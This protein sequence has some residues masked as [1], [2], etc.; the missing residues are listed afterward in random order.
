MT[1]TPENITSFTAVDQ[2][3]DPDFFVR[4]VDRANAL[5]SMQASK[6]ITLDAL[7]LQEG[8][9]VLDAGCGTGADVV[10]IARRV[11]PH[12][13]VVGVDVSETMVA[14]AR[15]RT[16]GTGLP[17]EFEVGDAQALRFADATFDAC[18]TERM[19]MHVPDAELALA[20][21]VRVT[22]PGGRVA[23]FDIDHDTPVIDS[24]YRDLTRAIVRSFSD[25][26]RH[27]W[28]GRQLPRLFREHGLADVTV[29]V[30]SVVGD[31]EMFELLWGGHVAQAQR[32][33]LLD[34]DEV[35]RWWEDLSQAHQA[36]C[37]FWGQ[38]AFVVGGTKP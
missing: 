29:T 12:G 3:D 31:Y 5:P 23:A 38:M 17:V 4:F 18:R 34:P 1:T 30:H 13:R 11:G 26:F 14:E 15:R 33:G 8:Q 7:R 32:D 2:T 22:K 21:L 10:E 6:P 20:E 24:P 9:V 27:G 25:D 35:K 36:G 16:A 19:L 28:I 37:F